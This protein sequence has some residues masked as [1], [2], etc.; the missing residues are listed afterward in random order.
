MKKWGGVGIFVM[1]DLEFVEVKKCDNNDLQALTIKIKA[2]K[3]H[4][5][6]IT[7]TYIPHRKRNNVNF[8]RLEN[9]LDTLPIDPED[10]HILCRDFNI[11]FLINSANFQK[12]VTLLAGNNLSIVESIE[13]TRE[14]SSTKPTFDAFFSNTLSSVHTTDSGN[15]DHHTV[16]LTFE[17]SVENSSKRHEKFKRKWVKLQNRKFVLN[18]LM[19]KLKTITCNISE[20]SPD[21]AFEKLH[22][23]LINTLNESLPII[24]STK[25]GVQK[26]GQIIR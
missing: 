16:T 12:I 26:N 23:I 25:T 19:D 20:W 9:Y 6:I 13:P 1:N 7:C 17:Q 4:Y 15:S 14:T 3:E 10:K 8:E 24:S 11:N 18:I 22:E 2:D 21:K 5:L